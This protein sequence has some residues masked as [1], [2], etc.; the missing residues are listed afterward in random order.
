M[1]S[2]LPSAFLPAD[3]P[4]RGVFCPDGGDSIPALRLETLTGSAY[5]NSS[6]PDTTATDTTDAGSTDTGSNV[7]S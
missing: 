7:G 3:T 4:T 5:Q 2:W 6:G 1:S